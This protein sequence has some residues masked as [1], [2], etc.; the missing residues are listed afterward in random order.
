ME[1]RK[2]QTVHEAGFERRS[3]RLGLHHGC[4][5]QHLCLLPHSEVRL[6]HFEKGLDRA[7]HLA[8]ALSK[9]RRSQDEGLDWVSTCDLVLMVMSM[10]IPHHPRPPALIDGDNPYDRCK[11]SIDDGGHELCCG[12]GQLQRHGS[13]TRSRKRTRL[14]GLSRRPTK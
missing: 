2:T 8:T 10:F 12:W 3:R 5:K 6:N 14:N 1:S 7:R 13:S 4:L 11:G 9:R